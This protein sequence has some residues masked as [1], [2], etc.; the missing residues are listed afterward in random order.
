[1]KKVLRVLRQH[2]N[3]AQEG[4]TR[5]LKY[6]GKNP[7]FMAYGTSFKCYIALNPMIKLGE[8]MNVEIIM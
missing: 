5:L 8:K 7:R 3:R 4:N 1:M 2:K 6:Q